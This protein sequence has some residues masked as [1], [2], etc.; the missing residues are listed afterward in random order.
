MLRSGVVTERQSS[1]PCDLR[2]VGCNMASPAPFP[3]PPLPLSSCSLRHLHL[4]PLPPD[5]PLSPTTPL[6]IVAVRGAMG[7]G[8][9][10]RP[11][12]LGRLLI[13]H[14]ISLCFAPLQ[15]LFPELESIE[16]KTRLRVQAYRESLKCAKLVTCD[17]VV[18]RK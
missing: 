13:Q 5:V 18:D 3:P 12:L 9:G 14:P 8:V 1:E 16:R 2:G 10:H 4:P 11:T 7:G 15:T 17:I 6:R